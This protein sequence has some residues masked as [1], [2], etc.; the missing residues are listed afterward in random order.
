MLKDRDMKDFVELVG[1]KVTGFRWYDNIY[2]DLGWVDEM[3]NSIG[4]EGTILEYDS[5]DDSFR[6]E[7]EN[8]DAYWH[9]AVEAV[10]HLV[11]ESAPVYDVNKTIEIIAPQSRLIEI[12]DIGKMLSVLP[13]GGEDPLYTRPFIQDACYCAYG[14]T[15]AEANDIINAAVKMNLF[16]LV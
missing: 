10:K 9:P 6:I 8:G 3:H 4:K 11:T 12:M 14:W 5:H 2:T 15:V 16:K 1:R 13:Y 7:F